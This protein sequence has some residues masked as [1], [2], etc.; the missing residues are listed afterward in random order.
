MKSHFISCNP[1]WFWSHLKK[2]CYRSSGGN[3]GLYAHFGFNGHFGI[4]TFSD[5]ATSLQSLPAPPQ[6]RPDWVVQ[7][8]HLASTVSLPTAPWLAALLL[9]VCCRARVGPCHPEEVAYSEITDYHVHKQSFTIGV[10]VGIFCPCIMLKLWSKWA[11]N[12]S[13]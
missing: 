10:G 11:G 1:I 13:S 2:N 6:T 7:I 8:S 12:N 3:F 4:Y 5:L 9:E